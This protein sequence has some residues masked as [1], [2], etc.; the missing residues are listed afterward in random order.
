MGTN[1]RVFFCLLWAFLPSA[2]AAGLY[3]DVLTGD[4][5]G[6]YDNQ[7]LYRQPSGALETH[8]LRSAQEYTPSGFDRS[9]AWI[10]ASNTAFH[11]GVETASSPGPE[12]TEA[13]IATAAVYW[14]SSPLLVS[15]WVGAGWVE[16]DG[17]CFSGG[18][19]TECSV[20]GS[21]DTGILL[22]P[23]TFGVASPVW[24][25]M[26]A[27]SQGSYTIVTSVA[28]AWF[29]GAVLRAFD[30]DMTPVPFSYAYLSDVSEV[31]ANPEPAAY[32]LLGGGLMLLIL[33]NRLYPNFARSR[34][35]RI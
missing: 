20:S 17:W 16:L 19:N 6:E 14:E 9:N 2:N 1:S 21:Q 32:W 13:G 4:P 12:G 33:R 11:A 34:N 10:S 28:D 18:D 26:D 3:L 8:A 24:F 27:R 5:A 23:I 22:M 15:G 30:S 35:R 25:R 29:T 31:T 7:N